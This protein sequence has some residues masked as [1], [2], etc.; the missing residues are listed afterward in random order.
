MVEKLDTLH[1]ENKKPFTGLSFKD[2]MLAVYD[3]YRCKFYGHKKAPKTL[4]GNIQFNDQIKR[5]KIKQL[6]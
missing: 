6:K 3:K 2:N 5:P 1:L 4:H